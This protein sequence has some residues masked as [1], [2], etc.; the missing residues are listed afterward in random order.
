[1]KQVITKN[2]FSA[3]ELSPTLYTRTDIQQYGNGAKTLKN[4]IPLVEGGVR[5][6][7]GT[8]FLSEQVGA[9]RLIPFVVNSDNTFLI[10]FKP[11]I[12]E[13]VNPKSLEVLESIVSPYTE[14][15]IHDI[16]FV[17]YRYEM[18]LTH[19]EVP[20]P[21]LLCDTAFDN[22]QLNQFVY[23]HLPTDSENARFP[24]RKG[25]PSGKDIGALVSFTLSSYNNWVSTQA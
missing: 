13:I 17:Q 5:K 24:F 7:P 4:V 12:V 1:M 22:W 25:K 6:R 16:Q 8:L 10:V 3:G 18:Y 15:Q 9:V 11:N 19:S 21:R 20:V 14:S 23:T 2:N